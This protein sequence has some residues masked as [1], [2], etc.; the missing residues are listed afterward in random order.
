MVQAAAEYLKEEQVRLRNWGCKGREKINQIH[1]CDL[2]NLIH[3]T[4]RKYT[5]DKA[6]QSQAS[7]LR[8]RITSCSPKRLQKC[9][10]FF[11]EF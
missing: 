7:H 3:A 8:L 2:K 4:M 11:L 6:K 9:K 10:T 1:L 5:K